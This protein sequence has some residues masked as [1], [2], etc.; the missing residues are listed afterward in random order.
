MPEKNRRALGL[1]KM[2]K[3]IFTYLSRWVVCLKLRL[4]YSMW[5]R[6]LQGFKKCSTKTNTFP[7]LKP[8]IRL[9]NR[10]KYLKNLEIIYF[11]TFLHPAL[12]DI[13]KIKNWWS[14]SFLRPILSLSIYGILT[15]KEKFK[16]ELVSNK[17][18]Q[19]PWLFVN[20][21]W[22]EFVLKHSSV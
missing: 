1:F 6:K 14:A 5:N 4:L 7:F 9:Q 20:L 18:I 8:N 19:S 3:Q 2:Q 22:R 12:Q 16:I 17:I 21:L 11:M 15:S 10:N 13:I